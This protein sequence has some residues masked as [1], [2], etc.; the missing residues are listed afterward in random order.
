M[1]QLIQKFSTEENKKYNS[2]DSGG[3]QCHGTLVELHIKQSF[4]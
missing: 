1:K 4:V 2:N 3:G